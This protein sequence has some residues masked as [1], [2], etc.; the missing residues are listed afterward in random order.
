MQ[1]LLLGLTRKGA[2]K[3]KDTRTPKIALDA[4][5][6]RKLIEQMAAA[7][8]SVHEAAPE[9]RDDHDE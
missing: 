7:I 3:P 6:R 2:S 1:R 9:T 4:R 8:A 5:T